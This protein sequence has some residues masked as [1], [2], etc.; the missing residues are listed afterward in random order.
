MSQ[1]PTHRR[2]FLSPPPSL[3]PSLSFL[4]SAPRGESLAAGSS[5]RSQDSSG[6]PGGV[7]ACSQSLAL[8]W[9]AATEAP[10]SRLPVIYGQLF[11]LCVCVF[12]AGPAA[13]Y[14]ETRGRL[15][16]TEAL[17]ANIMNERIK[18][19]PILDDLNNK[20]SADQCCWQGLR[21]NKG[22]L[23]SSDPLQQD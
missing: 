21:E 4:L 2:V 10:G 5:A 17:L 12:V 18:K 1:I 16:R 9:R 20:G 13:L 3:S 19:T 8:Q 23:L 6:G 11:V 15:G 14:C 22:V 7:K